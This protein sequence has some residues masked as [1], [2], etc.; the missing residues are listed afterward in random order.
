MNMFAP[1]LSQMLLMFTLILIGFCLK[2]KSILPDNA[3]VTMSKLETWVFVPALNFSNMMKNFTVKNF[4]S[5][6]R[7][8][9]CGAIMIVLALAIAQPLAAL[10]IRT[11]NKKH[12][13]ELMYQKNIYRYAMTF[14]NYGFMGNFIILGVWGEEMLA[15]Y[16]MFTMIIAVVC[17]SWG[18]YILI[19][20]DN[21][22][23]FLKNIKKGIITPPM[24]ALALGMICGMLNVGQ[25]IPE[26]FT[27][28]LGNASSCMGPVAML[29]AGFVIG[30]FDV[31]KM[32]SDKKVYIAT[33]VR[34]IVLPLIFVSVF[35]LFGVSKEILIFIL[36]C[37]GTP[38]GLNTIVYPAAYGGDTKTGASM[39]IISHTICVL[40]IPLMYMWLIG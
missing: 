12:D 34:L 19:P 39:A 13:S 21:N 40:T 28:M 22:V 31:K 33:F 1:T 4:A 30:R 35:K 37:F 36:I 26:F 17:S 38:L 32:L 3:Y 6:S 10:F 25:Y 2:K 14:G 29:L 24:I 5:N 18:L 27:N 16:L 15:Q 9:L 8:I 20:K 7:F 11:K 23:N